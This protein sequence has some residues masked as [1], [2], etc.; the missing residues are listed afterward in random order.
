MSKKVDTTGLMVKARYGWEIRATELA[1]PVFFWVSIGIDPE[2]RKGL[3]TAE[4]KR[5]D[6]KLELVR[7]AAS[8]M[9]AGMVKGT[10][11]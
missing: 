11:K 6:K 9:A 8:Y 1:K 4:N 7:Q 10:I 3:S 5:L 2:L